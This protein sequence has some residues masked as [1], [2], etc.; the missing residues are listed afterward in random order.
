[1]FKNYFKTAWR[2]LGKN[3][4][5]SFINIFG[6]A[7]GM[8]VAILIGL[9]I[10][11]ELSFNKYFKNYDRIAA[12][13]LNQTVNS[14]I[15]TGRAIS[16]PLDAELRKSYG[17]DF[18]HIVMMSFTEKHTLIAG[19]KKI[20]YHGNFMGAEGPAMLSLHMLEGGLSGLKGPSSMLISQSV[21]KAMFGNE[22]AVGKVIRLD[23]KSDF[24]ISGVYEDLPLNT[25]FNDL[26][27]IAPWD[28]YANHPDWIG[29][30]PA[31]WSD[32]SLFMYVQIADNAQIATVS[33]KI[34]NAI[35]NNTGEGVT[36]R[37]P[38]LFLQPMREWHLYS[39]FKN[40]VNTGGAIRYVWLFGIIGIF[41][42]LLACINFMNLSTARS[43]KRSKEVGIRKAIGSL[44]KQLIIR[45]FCDSLLMSVLSF[46]LSLALVWLA[47]PFFNEIA[48]KKMDIPL[49]SALFWM[50]CAGF[51]LFTGISAGSYPAL[52]LSSFNPVKVLK[53][54]FKAGRLAAVPRK[55]MV[56]LQFTVSVVLIIGTIVV[57]KQI[58][59]AKD[60]PVGY[61]RDGL[62]NIEITNND[63]P[64]HFQALR[65]DLLKSG[66]VTGVAGASSPTTGNKL[67]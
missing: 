32:Y 66:A 64:R 31:N 3:R 6:L 29:R 14:N 51:T 26:A 15:K 53:G 59:F 47:L 39:E 46:V 61:S 8:A 52:Y 33:Q 63:L 62:V 23:N 55:V 19:D 4:M 48:N 28:F 58:Q 65:E 7:I 12:V 60:R 1:M 45:F 35:L 67:Q 41:V 36:K 13:M 27:F 11:N 56:V 17:S 25:T 40:G 16:L 54:T 44:R 2:N 5:H 21:A 49:N 24:T 57:F 18:K 9:W 20:T 43:E 10:Y 37:K 50:L 38:E 42:L 22:D 34:K 30:D